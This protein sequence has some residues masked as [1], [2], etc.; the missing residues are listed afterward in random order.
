MADWYVSSVEY[1]AR[2]TWAAA[3]ALTVGTLRRPTAPTAG[4]ERT[5]RVSSISGTGTTGASEPTWPLTAGSTVTDN[6]GANQV[7][8]TE[9]SGNATY[10]PQ[11]AAAHV[12]VIFTQT[13]G[14]GATDGS[15]WVFVDSSHTEPTW[16]SARDWTRAGK[17][18]VVTW[19]GLTIPPVPADFAAGPVVLQTSG[20][21]NIVVAGAPDFDGFEFRC[22]SAASQAHFQIGRSA[23]S[24][25]VSV[26]NGKIKLNNTATGSRVWLGNI[27][28]GS[29]ILENCPL[30]FGNASQTITMNI[31]GGFFSWKNTASALQGTMPTSLFFSNFSGANTH[32]E[33][34]DLS[35][36]S[37][38]ILTTPS[39]SNTWAGVFRAIRCKLH[40][41]VTKAATW[42]LRSPGDILEFIA[43]DDSTNNKM[44]QAHKATMSGEINTTYAEYRD[45]A[46]ADA[47]GN[48]FSF[49]AKQSAA[50]NGSPTR[51]LHNIIY[52]PEHWNETTGSPITATV[53]LAVEHTALVSRAHIWLEALYLGDSGSPLATSASSMT[54]EAPS[55]TPTAG[56]AS[57][58]NWSATVRTNSE[59]P[60]A[61]SIRSV[62][63]NAGRLFIVQTSGLFSGSLPAAYATAVD[64][65]TV[66]DGS[67]TLRAMYRQTVSVTFTPTRQG[68]IGFRVHVV[69]PDTAQK[70]VLVD[71]TAVLS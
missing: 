70:I 56:T 63:S 58:E 54:A 43:C 20:A 40:A 16:T 5:Y 9:V 34:L 51:A 36:F 53:E 64:G 60:A 17:V 12:D 15:D 23:L 6:A 10:A 24:G 57:T 3:T 4:N 13:N 28:A 61:G 59:T 69:H 39:G 25:I 30:E 37:G 47:D 55:G 29:L 32:L 14:R 11:S 7:V 26:R 48:K 27:G 66:T 19:S 49:H 21:S 18:R 44:S 35:S 50:A 22:G 41:S 33:N 68:P 62:S 67:A 31:A 65:D 2:T 1:A 8:W 38:T 52:L 71:P 45:A 42:K 46:V